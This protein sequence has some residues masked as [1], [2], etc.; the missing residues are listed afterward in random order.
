MTGSCGHISL[1]TNILSPGPGSMHHVI[2]L[3]KQPE[4]YDLS[5]DFG[6]V[7]HV[8]IRLFDSLLSEF[9]LLVIRFLG[10]FRKNKLQKH[11]AF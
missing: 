7:R 2:H 4:S 3:R 5:L 1:R 6:H 10:L 9:I 8:G 11:N